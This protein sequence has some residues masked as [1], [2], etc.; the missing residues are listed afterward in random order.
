M[1]SMGLGNIKEQIVVKY[2]RILYKKWRTVIYLCTKSFERE[3]G[4]EKQTVKLG[5]FTSVKGS[6]GR[7]V[8]ERR[9]KLDIGSAVDTKLF[10]SLLK[11]VDH[12]R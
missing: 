1:V 8:F 4:L 2:R 9:D 3:V 7:C 10:W 11:N 12:S 6:G 5:L